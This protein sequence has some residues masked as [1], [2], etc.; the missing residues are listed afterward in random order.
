M[1]TDDPKEQDKLYQPDREAPDQM[2]AVE[3]V[4]VV[5][6]RPRQ[7]IEREEPPSSVKEERRLHRLQALRVADESRLDVLKAQTFITREPNY[8]S[9]LFTKWDNINRKF[10]LVGFVNSINYKAYYEMWQ[11]LLT[12]LYELA[13]NVPSDQ[14]QKSVSEM[15]QFTSWV[16]EQP[17]KERIPLLYS[18][19]S[20]LFYSTKLGLARP[21]ESSLFDLKAEVVFAEH[22]KKIEAAQKVTELVR[23]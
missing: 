13:G 2:D 11:E 15:K 14:W 4:P 19:A 16:R 18:K 3:A 12:F 9:A 5:S 21:K 22:Y 23:K 7:A 20:N 1:S 10:H 6:L 17:I 8:E